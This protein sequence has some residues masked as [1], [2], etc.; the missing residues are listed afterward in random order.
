MKTTTMILSLSLPLALMIACGEGG[1]HDDG[2]DDAG[3]EE[4]T[5]DHGDDGIGDGD[6]DGVI[7]DGDGD[8]GSA[9]DGSADDDGHL[10]DSGGDG[11]GSSSGGDGDDGDGD[12][13]DGD[14]GGS[15]DDGT[16]CGVL[17]C[18]AVEVELVAAQHYDAGWVT[19]RTTEEG[20]LVEMQMSAPWRLDMVHIYA[21]VDVPALGAPGSFP[22]AEDLD[23]ATEYAMTIPF[24]SLDGQCGET[25]RVAVH[26]EVTKPIEGGG[27]KQETAWGDGEYS[28]G[29]GGGSYFEVTLCCD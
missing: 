29:L 11:G 1:Q 19:V 20:L 5:G 24:E 9:D 3:V 15:D 2:L 27:C 17:E 28:L 14:A 8:G 21:G 22:H 6:G 7:G 26:A 25:L 23:Y 16:D 4:G 12:D 10:R 13:G 18:E